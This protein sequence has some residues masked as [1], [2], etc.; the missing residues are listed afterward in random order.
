MN[1]R[2]ILIIACATALGLI[3]ILVNYGNTPSE[4]ARTVRLME[5]GVQIDV[6]GTLS[7]MTYR[8]SA[9][10]G[11][12][13]VLHMTID[14]TCEIGTIYSVQKK[15]I[16]QSETEWTEEKLKTA[17]GWSD[18]APPLVKEFTDFYLVLE[19]SKSTCS[20][21]ERK[22]EAETKKRSDLQSAVSTAQFIRF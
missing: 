18:D 16:A 11:I 12:G 8:T 1:K 21:D 4:S 2:I 17:T 19:P 5:L 20:E 6:P 15:G 13:T 9:A 3:A 7:D 10:Q 22:K 14:E